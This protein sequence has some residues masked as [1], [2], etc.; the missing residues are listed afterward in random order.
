MAI[1]G[2][3]RKPFTRLFWRDCSGSVVLYFAFAA[4]PMMAMLGLAVDYG[5]TTLARAATQTAMDSAVLA[6]LQTPS[7]ATGAFMAGASR[8][9]LTVTSGPTFTTNADGSVSGAAT[10]QLATSLVGALGLPAI[11]FPVYATA[12]LGKSAS[13]TTANKVCILVLDPNNSQTLLVNSNFAMSAPNCEIDVASTANPAAIFNSGDAIAAQNVCIK[14]PRSNIIQNSVSVANLTPGCAVAA[15]PYA[16]KLPTVSST[17]CT[18][19]DQNY[20]GTNTLSPGVYCGNFNFNG[21]GALN[22]QPGL[23]VFK[24][25]RWNINS[26]WS[27]SGTGVTFYFADSASY[28]QLNSGVS[29]NVNA[30]TSGTYANILIYEPTGL[31]TSALTINAGANQT[32]TGLIYLPSRNLTFNAGSNLSSESLTLIVNQLI[33]DSNSPSTWKLAPGALAPDSATFSTA[34]TTGSGAAVLTH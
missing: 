5:R 25:T 24:G 29:V 1:K 12:K 30:P 7:A 31:S 19:S 4:I 28:I 8:N 18:V 3:A 23:Y 33:L 34:T 6:A 16:G 14:A 17:T 15:D 13:A 27:L 10:A 11:S 20:S 26:G 22:L 32:M 9:G 21:S 2:I